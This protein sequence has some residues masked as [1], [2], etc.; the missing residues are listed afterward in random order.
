MATLWRIQ[1]TRSIRTIG[2][3]V[4]HR[5]EGAI[6]PIGAQANS[7]VFSRDDLVDRLGTG[8][9][10]SATCIL[11]S[12]R[13]TGRTARNF[14]HVVVCGGPGHRGR[15]CTG[16]RGRRILANGCLSIANFTQR[17][18]IGQTSEQFIDA[19]ASLANPPRGATDPLGLVS[20]FRDLLNNLADSRTDGSDDLV[21]FTTLSWR[22]CRDWA[23]IDRRP[24][25]VPPEYLE[26]PAPGHRLRRRG[27]MIQPHRS[28][29]SR[30]SPLKLRAL[31]AV[32]GKPL[33][34]ATRSKATPLQRR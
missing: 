16:A 26:D 8:R 3:H 32:S 31:S 9:T 30:R 11:D 1:L 5:I 14:N 29:P 24:G 20:A 28:N 15:R 17:T 21:A 25:L 18:A 2:P 4:E 13:R 6:G 33:T 10:V 19:R 7:R 23:N 27:T 22:L 12:G 34:T